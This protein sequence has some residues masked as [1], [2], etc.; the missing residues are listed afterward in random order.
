MKF[1]TVLDKTLEL[2]KERKNYFLTKHPEL[3]P[4]FAK[5]KSVLLEPNEIRRSKRNRKVLLFYKYFGTILK[6]KYIVVVAKLNKRNFI[7]TGYVTD[8][9][10]IGEKYP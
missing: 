2:T 7:L 1:K 3:K 4:Y 9:I 5:I 8:K 6:G 10:K